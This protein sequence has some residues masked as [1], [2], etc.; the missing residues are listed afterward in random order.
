[1]FPLWSRLN[2]IILRQPCWFS[3]W[4]SLKESYDAGGGGGNIYPLNSPITKIKLFNS[5]ITK[6]SDLSRAVIMFHQDYIVSPVTILNDGYDVC[7]VMVFML[8]QKNCPQSQKGSNTST[9]IS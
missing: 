6:N 2:V 9:G 5:S 3:R 8:S 1:M 4:Q 7:T